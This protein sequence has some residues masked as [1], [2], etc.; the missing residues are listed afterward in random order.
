MRV[1]RTASIMLVSCVFLAYAFVGPVNSIPTVDV[2]FTV[3][4]VYWGTIDTTL[5]PEPGDR[6]VPLTIVI[7]QHSDYYLRGIVG[8]LNL[9]EYF[10][11]SVSK[12]NVSS[13]QGI[14]IER[15]NDTGDVIPYGSFYLTFTL[16]ISEE[17]NKGTYSLNLRLTYYAINSSG[18]YQLSLIHI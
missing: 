17:A 16:D 1:V 6:N 4:K 10:R 9:S 14:A 7:Q 15:E 3:V 5:S 13:A 12:G 18:Y 11:D 8:Y 2:E